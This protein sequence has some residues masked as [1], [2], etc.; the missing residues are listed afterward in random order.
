ML[1]FSVLGRNASLK[2]REVYVNY[3]NHVKERE[4]IAGVLS[5]KYP[6]LNFSVAGETG[7]DILPR[8][9]DKSQ[10]LVDFNVKDVVFF[11]DKTQKGGND[12]EIATAVIAGGGIV[13]TV[14]DWMDTWQILSQL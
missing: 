9:W 3:D 1:N 7:I 6:E 8:G 10:I 5:T 11:G 12:H 13:H 4:G 2:E 14:N